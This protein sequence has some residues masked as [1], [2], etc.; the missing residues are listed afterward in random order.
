[1]F[2]DKNIQVTYV[3]WVILTKIKLLSTGRTK[4]AHVF[5]FTVDLI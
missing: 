5:R 2:F 4:T 1:M 3:G